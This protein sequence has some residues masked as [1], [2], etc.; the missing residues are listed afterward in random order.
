MHAALESEHA[1]WTL[2][3][4]GDL[5]EAEVLAGVAAS[6]EAWWAFLDEREAEASL[7]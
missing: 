4:A 2:D 7:V 6:S 5:P 1:D 3:A